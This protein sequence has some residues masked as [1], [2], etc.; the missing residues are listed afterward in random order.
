MSSSTKEAQ[1]RVRESIDLFL[2]EVRRKHFNFLEPVCFEECHHS[3]EA[4]EED[5]DRKV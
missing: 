3:H 1:K 5:L 2:D 4:Y